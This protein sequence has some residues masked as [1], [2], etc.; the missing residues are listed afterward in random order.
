MNAFAK[1]FRQI[2]V[3]Q[4]ITLREISSET[5]KSIAYLSDVE[6]GRRMPPSD[7]IVTSIE[8]VF[9]ITDGGLLKLAKSVK[10]AP[11]DFTYLMRNNPAVAN[12]AQSLMR[13][14]NELDEDEVQQIINEM[15]N[16][17]SKREGK[18]NE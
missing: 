2:R 4:E 7:E 16:T 5:G 8:K 12:L 9:G 13:I 11:K 14:D 15:Q 3:D 18:K 1:K 10:E 17:L 6:H